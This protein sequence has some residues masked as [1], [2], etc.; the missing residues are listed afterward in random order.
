MA[1]RVK[2]GDSDNLEAQ[3]ARRSPL[4]MGADFGAIATAPAPMPCSTALLQKS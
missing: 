4:L 2:S 3:A 1:R